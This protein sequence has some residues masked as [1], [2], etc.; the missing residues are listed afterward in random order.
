MADSP[1][2]KNIAALINAM[3]HAAA[4]FV[5]QS[6]ISSGGMGPESATAESLQHQFSD[7]PQTQ[8]SKS[9]NEFDYSP[10]IPNSMD[11]MATMGTSSAGLHHSQYSFGPHGHEHFGHGDANM[12]PI[13]TEAEASAMLAAQ[14]GEYLQA[15]MSPFPDVLGMAI[16]SGWDEWAWQN[17]MRPPSG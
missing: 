9:N 6:R 5:S 15:G 10:T 11:Q 14:Q 3:Y 17:E 13:M 2:N 7:V 12:P 16:G 4:N 1:R 8:E